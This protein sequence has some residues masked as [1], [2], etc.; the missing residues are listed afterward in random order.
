MRLY[1]LDPLLDDR[2]C[3]LVARHP[4]AS[5]FHSSSWLRA[6]T[7]TYGYRAMVVTSNPPGE[8]LSNGLALCEVRSWITGSRLVSL[9]FSDHVQPLLDESC[10]IFDIGEWIRA[11][12]SH[13]D[14]R[15]IEFRPLSGGFHAEHRMQAS[16]SFWFHSL[17]L[18]PSTEQ[19][20]RK[21]HRNCIQRRIRH[22][23]RQ[24]LSYRRGCSTELL[25]AFYELLTLTRK[26]HRLLPQPRAWFRNLLECMG[27]DAEIRLV[28]KDE[29]PVAAILTLRHRNAV[30]Y[31]YGCSDRKL[32]HL[33]GMALLFWRLIEESKAEGAE[34][35]DFGRTDMD[36]AGLTRFKDRLGALRTQINYFRCTRDDRESLTL[37]S[38]LPMTRALCSTLPSA[39]S[40]MAGE[41]IYRH[42][43]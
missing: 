14:W 23:E 20:F 19:L 3:D 2:W 26:R 38:R 37:A 15:Y 18:S 10:G 16:E 6:L 13:E 4:G 5:V 29:I 9:P 22:A 32:H 25:D 8:A 34:Q 17:D 11:E 1:T 30:V 43:G 7:R 40:T 24:G 42:M 35:I 28:R 39:L 12:C 41:L 21:T 31:K 33:G 36:N 27:P